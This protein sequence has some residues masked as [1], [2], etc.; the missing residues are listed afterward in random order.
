MTTETT[1][2][3]TRFFAPQARLVDADTNNV[4]GAT[5]GAG[6][7]H[8]A[9]VDLVS[10]KVTLAINNVCLLQVVLNNQR[11]DNGRPVF[12]P[13]KYNNLSQI[14]FGQRLRLD[15]RYGA[16]PWNKMILARVTDLQFGFPSSGASQLTVVGEDLLSLLKTK[17]GKEHPY[18]NRKEDFIVEN[19]LERSKAAALGLTFTGVTPTPENP[20]KGPLVAWPE[21]QPLRSITHGKD[22]NFLAFL[23][24]IAERMDFEMFVDFTERLILDGDAKPSNA[25]T[26]KLHFEPARSVVDPKQVLDLRWGTNLIEFTPKLKV[27]DLMTE[28][29]VGGTRHGKRKPERKTIKPDDAAIKADL[30]A[31]PEYTFTATG[32]S[33][34]PEVTKGVA[35]LGASGVR[36]SFFAKEG[37][38]A[39]NP[40]NVNTANLD[41]DRVKLQGI[42]TLR[43]SMRQLLTA[44][45]STIGFPALRPGIYVRIGGLYP[46]FDGLYYVTQTVHSFDGSGYRTQFSLRRPGLL[47]PKKYPATE[48]SS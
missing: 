37:T 18:Q 3:G 38:P 17:P 22:T 16:D 12:P 36:E 4:I 23:Q 26:V 5:P 45:A 30:K 9:V 15:L 19:V 11:N 47:D 7:S 46:P 41:G 43:N 29:T 20:Q 32:L 21:L 14:K 44:E 13:W 25:N 35:L 24:S 48:A 10:A 33:G 8:P 40:G 39:P 42:A 27:W 31:D 2:P 34:K 1:N 28:V 6:G